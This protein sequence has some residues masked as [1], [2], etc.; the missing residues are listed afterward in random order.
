MASTLLRRRNM[1]KQIRMAKP[2][3]LPQK[4][5][6]L[7]ALINVYVI[8]QFTPFD[9]R[10]KTFFDKCQDNEKFHLEEFFFLRKSVIFC[11][12]PFVIM[13]RVFG[14]GGRQE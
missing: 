8:A 13:L 6:F 7:L 3:V 4:R 11:P 1:S 10:G 5:E 2:L 12:F 14:K 9:R